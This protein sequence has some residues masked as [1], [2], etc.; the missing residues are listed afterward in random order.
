MRRKKVLS[1]LPIEAHIDSLSHDGR[2]IATIEGKKAF[3]FGALPGERVNFKLTASK[4]GYDEGDLVE[5]LS[6]PSADRVTPPCVHFG[7]CGGCNSQH[8]KQEAALAHKQ[9]VVLDNMLHMGQVTPEEVLP[10]IVGPT[11]GYRRKARLGVRYVF[12]KESLLVGFR[13][14]TSNRIAI[15]DSCKI[16][17]PQVGELISD[18]KILIRALDR[19]ESIAQIEVAIGMDTVALVIRHLEALSSEDEAAFIAFAKTHSDINLAIYLQPKGPETVHKLYPDDQKTL[20]EYELTLN[21]QE[22][23]R[24]QFHPLDFVQV[25]VD[26]N[27]K[28]VNQALELLEA[29]PSDTI[30]DLFCGLGNFTLPIAKKAGVVVGVEGALSS[31]VRAKANA[32][33]NGS[34]NTQFYVKDLTKPLDHGDEIWA[35][36]S[37]DKI[38]L[39][40]P[41]TGA[42]EIVECIDRW[43]AKVIVYISCNPA[44]LARDAGIL[45]HQK[46]YRLKKL[47]I[48]D[49]FPH[50]AHVE[51]MALFV[52]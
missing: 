6:E 15:M 8:L 22:V 50:T 5:L 49:M 11:Q 10:P 21:T 36:I 13:E 24:F 14:R 31:I 44:T 37:Y 25:N 26:I 18:L 17:D 1:T 3:V 35:N 48:I 12:K 19:F 2:G 32:E 9:K 33:L 42:K 40:P 20:L 47:G 45:V 30:L 29:Q 52:K 41:R 34:D 23:L 28:M 7:Q 51:T 4:K 39:D 38:V 27:Q 46:G 16:L 43:K